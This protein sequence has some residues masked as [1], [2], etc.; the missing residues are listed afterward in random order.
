MYRS[1]VLASF[2]MMLPMVCP[3]QGYTIQF[4]KGVNQKVVSGWASSLDKID[5]TSSKT[6]IRKKS[7]GKDELHRVGH[8]DVI[9]WIP[10]TTDVTQDFILVFW[11]HGH[12]GY[13]PHRTFQDRT[14]KQFVPLARSKNFVVVIP[15]MPWSIHA[16]TPTKRNSLVW[17]K[18]GDFLKFV[19]QV[20]GILSE[21]MNDTHPTGTTL[22]TIDYRVVGHSAGGSTIKRLGM[23]GDLCKISPSMVV[24]S[25]SSYGTW[26]DLAW[27]GCLK[28]NNI[29]TK[30]FVKKWGAPYRSIMRF[31]NDNGGVP[32]KAGLNI[33]LH[34][35][36]H[37]S[38]GDNI[39]KLSGLLED[40][41]E[42]D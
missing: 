13:V 12:Y 42:V 28:D 9:V 3:A 39:V 17:T 27:K 11:F 18:P 35:W 30:V 21:H 24:W 5:D 29:P 32:K 41:H 38:I 31:V 6:Y 22:G 20:K 4:N 14:L 16:K 19:T 23:T 2:I 34:P 1:T 40:H 36:T 33:M 15:E 37:K 25:D 8:R 10:E 7:G 26:F